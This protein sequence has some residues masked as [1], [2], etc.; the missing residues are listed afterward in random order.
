MATPNEAKTFTPPYGIP[1]ATFKNFIE[2]VQR[3]EADAEMPNKIDRTF[4]KGLSGT[5]QTYLMAALKAF[6]L[7][8][9]DGTVLPALKDLAKD[10][11]VF[12]DKT[13]DLL[14]KYYGIVL[15]L[16]DKNATQGDLEEAFRN[17]GVTGN[18]MR[19]AITFFMHGAQ[20]AG[21]T[22]SPHWGT[23]KI[24]SAPR[25]RKAEASGGKLP[26]AHEDGPPRTPAKDG[27]DMKREY[28]GLLMEKVRGQDAE[29]DKD[30]LDRIERLLGVAAPDAEG[31]NS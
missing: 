31:G 8:G 21:L 24:Q 11:E 2:R 3:L 15:E 4:L 7:I 6:E 29:M 19:K 28:I 10:P 25:K 18:T 23:P 1:W 12:P 22:L 26:P 27:T 14:A 17:Y 20:F 16:A 5:S 30:L 13:S 9:P